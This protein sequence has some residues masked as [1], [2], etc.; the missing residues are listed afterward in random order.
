MYV[1]VT[2]TFISLYD[3]LYAVPNTFGMVNITCAPVDLNNTCIVT[4]NVS[5]LMSVEICGITIV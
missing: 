2:Y 1:Y 4:W 5:N 3:F